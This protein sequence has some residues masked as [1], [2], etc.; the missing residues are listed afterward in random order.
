MNMLNRYLFIVFLLFN[1]V[2]DQLFAQPAN[3][4]CANAIPLADVQGWCSEPRAYTLVGATQSPDPLPFCFPN[5]QTVRDLWFSF[6]AVATDINV[7]V[8]GNVAVNSGGSLNNPQLAV[9]SGNCGNLTEIECISDAFGSNVA[10]TFGGPLTIGQTYYIRVSARSSNVGT[11]Q[12]CVNN[13]NNVP[14]PSGDC[15]TAAILCDKSSFTVQFV[16]GTGFDPNEI[17]NTTCDRSPNCFIE[18]SSSS[19]YKWTCDQSGSLTFSLT[20]VNPADDLDFLLYELPNG[21]DNCSNKQEIRCMA[22]GENVGEPLA[23]WAACTGATGLSTNDSDEFENCGCEAGD[24]NFVS[25]VDLVAGRS[26]A[27][28]VNNFSNSG[29]GF[30]VSFGGSSTFVGPKAAFNSVPD[31]QVCW[32]QSMTFTDASSYIGTL[33]SWDWNFGSNAS[34]ATATGPGPH[35]VSWTDIGS[36]FIVLSVETDRGCVV[37]SVETIEVAPCCDDVNAISINT[38]ITDVSCP[39]SLDGA[40]DLSAS[41][42]APITGFSWVTGATTEDVSN[43]GQGPYT[44]TISNE[45]TCDSVF[46]VTIGGPPPFVFNPIISMPTCMGGMDGAID[47]QLTGGTPPYMYNWGSGFSTDNTLSNL[48]VG[49]YSVT[50]Q[51]ANG[52]EETMDIPVNELELVLNQAIPSVQPPSCHDS[53]DGTI[54]L[55]IANGLP[56]Y[57]FDWNDGNGFVS[58]NAMGGLNTATFTI[59]FRDAN[60]CLGDTTISIIPPDPLLVIIDPVDISCFGAN[61]GQAVPIVSGGVGNYSFQ[62]SDPTAQTD[63]VATGLAPG[64]YLLTVTDGNGCDTIATTTVI[65]P[66]EL[67]LDLISVEDVICNGESTGAITVL[68]TGGTPP[69]QYSIN[70]VEFQDAPTFTNLPAGDYTI[71]VRDAMDCEHS[72][73]A[74]VTQPPPLLVDAGVDKTVDLG[75]SATLNTTTSPPLRPVTY[76]WHPTDYLS[77]TDCPGPVATP[78]NTTTYT[79]LITD[80]DGC[81][82][83]DEVTVNV[84]KNRPIFIPNAF[85]PNA[86][87][88]NDFFT[89]FGG[90]AAQRIELLRIYNRWGALIFEVR[91]I[92]LNDELLGWDGTFKGERLPPDVFAYYTVIEFIDDERLLFEGDISIVK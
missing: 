36:K 92:D 38:N 70:G 3:D 1:T 8:I 44:V 85:S 56:P 71:I 37:T 6:V 57:E 31:Q 2:A 49:L 62:W 51:D 30:S 80:E 7:S 73:A 41:S 69:Y 47:L 58:N 83:T 4:E 52:C 90:P 63:S 32:G 45:A 21:I 22:S 89:V 91:D 84:V 68:G 18:E 59:N 27:L 26:Y 10:E 20:P 29:S 64:P 86:D 11:F 76:S 65:E 5:N 23:N 67:F 42:N 12:L 79:V 13:F 82:A 15:N 9:Y 14:E 19:W 43:L 78:P 48:P 72:V 66:P 50:I 39:N 61:D 34:P 87:G 16:N 88:I 74:S 28:V 17:S 60:G 81:T 25:A 33:T 40:I 55:T 46:E 35:T 24:N 54:T 77:C 53:F 75:Y